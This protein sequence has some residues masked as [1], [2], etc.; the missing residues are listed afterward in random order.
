MDAV[1]SWLHL[2]GH[3]ISSLPGEISGGEDEEE[4]EVSI[5]HGV[6][7]R[8]IKIVGFTIIGTLI[9]LAFLFAAI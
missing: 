3:G 7:M 1:R 2:L 8:I 4:E 5:H 6:V 9:V